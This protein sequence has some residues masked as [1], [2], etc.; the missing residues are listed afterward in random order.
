MDAMASD[1]R[2]EKSHPRFISQI[3]INQIFISQMG[4]LSAK[5]LSAEYLIYQPNI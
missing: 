3:F 1:R 2:Q 4:Y 5:Y